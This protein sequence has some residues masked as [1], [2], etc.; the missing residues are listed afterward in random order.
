MSYPKIIQGG[1]GVA[2]SAWP[3]ARAV[4]LRG[5]LGV[6]SGTGID[7]IFAR[8]LQLGD[9]G[10][11]MATALAHFPVREIA[12]RV[13]ERYFVPGGKAPDAPFK[14]KPVPAVNPPKALVELTVV[15]NFVEIWLAKQGHG[16]LVGINLLEKIQLPT[17]QS[18]YGAMLAGVD[19]VLMGAGIPRAIPGVLDSL[20]AGRRTEMKIDVAGGDSTVTRFDPSA[21][22]QREVKRPEFFPIVSSASLAQILVHKC[23]PPADG[24]VVEGPT[25]GGHNAPPRGA[26]QLS[27]E[28]EPIYG[29]RDLPDFQKFRDLGRPFWLAGSYGKPGRLEDALA[30]GAQG[31]QVGT[32]FAFCD[33]SGIRADIKA[34]VLE[35][36]LRHE[37]RVFTDPKASPTGFPFKV[38]RLP[39]SISEPEVREARTR[40]CDLGYL[41][42][43]YLKPDGTL[44]YRCA[45]EPL[46]DYVRKGGDPANAVG[47]VCVCNGLMATVGMGQ[48]RKGVP[49][50]VL[51]TAGDDVAHV[52]QY[53]KPG[54]TTYTADDVI[55]A[56]LG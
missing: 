16:G 25:A 54:R 49:E 23:T 12:E 44:G 37:A 31:I 30:V 15:A 8:R 4:S 45:S 46:E 26:L 10:G 20:A 2:V 43:C 55:D 51:V 42:E 13:W 36:S 32:A 21:F 17:L 9:L 29:E 14:S 34:A 50:P 22:G 39:G 52:A 7:A 53:L 5:Q 6:V 19:V 35:Q 3:L 11:H 47:R 41:R 38:V 28:G 18:L 40:S 27:E 56:L 24:F 1:M 33:E 48:V